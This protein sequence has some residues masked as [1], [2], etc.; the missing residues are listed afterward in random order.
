MNL[1]TGSLRS[2]SM[3][4]LELVIGVAVLIIIEV[5]LAFAA[6]NWQV[7][8]LTFFAGAA[9]LVAFFWRPELLI[10]FHFAVAFFLPE[11][12]EYQL[13]VYLPSSFLGEANFVL[14]DLIFF[15]TMTIWIAKMLL[16]QELKLKRT[17]IDLQIGVLFLVIVVNVFVSLVKGNYVVG[18]L[19]DFRVFA[20]ILFYFYF[21]V[22]VLK[23]KE[24]LSFFLKAVA[25]LVVVLA[26]YQIYMQS[27]VGFPS[28]PKDNVFHQWIL[29]WYIWSLVI[30]I[31]FGLFRQK[32]IAYFLPALLTLPFV[33]LSYSKVWVV[34]LFAGI[35]ISIFVLRRTLKPKFLSSTA[36]IVMGIGIFT[37]VLFF[38]LKINVVTMIVSPINRL[39]GW[40]E[41]ST[42]L[43]RQAQMEAAWGQIIR[44]PLFG[45][46][47][48]SFY[49]FA[50]PVGGFF[51]AKAATVENDYWWVLFRLG[52]L[53][54]GAF[55]WL[56]VSIFKRG[57]EALKYA[58]DDFTQ[59]LALAFLNC[60]VFL[61][62]FLMGGSIL[63]HFRIGPTFGVMAGLVVA[64]YNIVKPEDEE[65]TAPLT[66]RLRD[67][68][69]RR[70]K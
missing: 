65:R 57:V 14:F 60:F 49:Q 32:K 7:Q 18:I 5:L 66:S 11:M 3:K 62:C 41:E 39:F 40:Q 31:S 27:K 64:L 15:V 21:T 19:R 59:P 50:A 43:W 33:V 54:L 46:G 48:G 12:L 30:L 25:L 67:V 29:I 13:G 8:L 56:A 70:G 1:T 38:V 24:R 44:D 61:L 36:T 37:I 4:T 6:A 10:L 52:F 51:E 9:M 26:G 53:G 47:L 42:V 55:I 22:N 45:G 63:T 58:K 34:A 20:V 35:V 23:D 28:S 2:R 69:K 17:S 68:G 16:S